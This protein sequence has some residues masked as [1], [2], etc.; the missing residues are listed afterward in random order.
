[1]IK[2]LQS[3]RERFFDAYTPMDATKNKRGFL[4]INLDSRD[5]KNGLF[6]GLLHYLTDKEGWLKPLHKIHKK[7]F[8]GFAVTNIEYEIIQSIRE[9]IGDILCSEMAIRKGFKE[10]SYEKAIGYLERALKENTEEEL[11]KLSDLDINSLL[12]V[13]KVYGQTTLPPSYP[14]REEVKKNEIDPKRKKLTEYLHPNVKKNLERIDKAFYSIEIPPTKENIK[15]TYLE[16]FEVY[17]SL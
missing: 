7:L 15:R 9:Q 6:E 3:S 11:K 1:M 14:Q 2:S 4:A 17:W 5:P 13:I 8:K 12:F 10:F 16:L